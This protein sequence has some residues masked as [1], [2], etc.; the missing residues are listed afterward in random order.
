MQRLASVFIFGSE[1]HLAPKGI[2]EAGILSESEAF[3]RLCI[4][5]SAPEADLLTPHKTDN[6]LWTAEPLP[7]ASGRMGDST[8]GGGVRYEVVEGRI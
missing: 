8:G 4:A 5:L 2:Q 3:V 7:F 6:S 1:N